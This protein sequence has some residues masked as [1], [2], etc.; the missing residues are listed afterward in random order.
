MNS[1]N[2]VTG[3]VIMPRAEFFGAQQLAVGLCTGHRDP[4]EEKR[5]WAQDPL[6]GPVAAPALLALDHL[7]SAVREGLAEYRGGND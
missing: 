2:R 7:E 4:A 6:T 3:T 1:N 5:N